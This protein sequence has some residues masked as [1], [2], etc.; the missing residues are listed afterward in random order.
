VLETIRKK[1]Q[2]MVSGLINL[3]SSSKQ[4]ASAAS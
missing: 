2:S 1:G 4:T 3:F